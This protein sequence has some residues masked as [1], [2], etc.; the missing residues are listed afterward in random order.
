M[1]G[2]VDLLFQI[3]EGF[4][5]FLDLVDIANSL[6]DQSGYRGVYQLATFHP[7]YQFE[8]AEQNCPGNYTNRS[9]YPTLHLI[10]ESSLERV[11]KV[12]P[13][14]ENIPITNQKKAEELGLDFLQNLLVTLRNQG[15]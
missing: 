9:P 5:Y 2:Q 13:S 14:P 6:I 10:R 3:G 8:G 11:L 1:T 15:N 12:H 4:G 7:D